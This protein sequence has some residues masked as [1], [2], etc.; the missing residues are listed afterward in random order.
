[1]QLVVRA[2]NF[3]CASA[4]RSI[5]ARIAM[6]AITTSNSMSVNAFLLE[7][8]ASRVFTI[9][10]RQAGADTPHAGQMMVV[11]RDYPRTLPRANAKEFGSFPRTDW[12]AL[13]NHSC[14]E[15]SVH[16]GRVRLK[17]L[18]R[19]ELSERGSVTCSNFVKQNAL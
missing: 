18:G 2:R 10:P 5:A 17:A 1:M 15:C 13:Y 3:A 11:C 6:M 12:N 19:H 9:L 14:G 16:Q 8:D 4:G 7:M